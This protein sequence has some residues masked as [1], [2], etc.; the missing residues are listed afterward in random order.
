VFTE[1]RGY[2]GSNGAKSGPFPYISPLAFPPLGCSLREGVLGTIKGRK[3]DHFLTSDR[4][5]SPTGA[6]TERGGS[7]DSKGAKNRP[8]PH[9]RLHASIP[10]PGAF[11]ERGGSFD[12][13]GSKSVAF[14]LI[15][16]P[17]FHP[18]GCSLR[19]GVPFTVK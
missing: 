13:K 7:W 6:F 8:F 5:H 19:E 4:Q 14:P 11:T 17:A 3:V 15:R 18:Q 1:R 9:I 10:P 2:F 16:L 12:S